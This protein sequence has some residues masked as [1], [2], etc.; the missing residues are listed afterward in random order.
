MSFR[1]LTRLSGVSLISGGVLLAIGSAISSLL[2]PEGLIAM[3]SSPLS[4]TAYA[5]RI[6]GAVLLLLGLP[7]VVA[8]QAEGSRAVILSL[9]G[10]LL[11]FLGI[12][13]LEVG[14]NSIYAFVFPPMA[15]NISSRPVL[16]DLDANRPLGASIAY[17]IGLVLETFG[18][19][20]LGIGILRA[21]VL[22][23]MAGIMFVIVPLLF[24]LSLPDFLVFQAIVGVILAAAIGLGFVSCGYGLLSPRRN[25]QM[26]LG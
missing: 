12:A 13:M 9:I 19:L 7:A 8:R 20:I 14:M 21:K 23:R 4:I 6:V 18:P 17:T 26:N 11:L 16:L 15:T 1:M 5:L 10:F 24:I 22:P 25:E 3:Y 2:L